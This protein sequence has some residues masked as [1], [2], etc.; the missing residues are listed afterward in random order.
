MFKLFRAKNDLDSIY[1]DQNLKDLYFL[2]RIIKD[3][4]GESIQELGNFLKLKINSI[5]TLLENKLECQKL[6]LYTGLSLKDCQDQIQLLQQYEELGIQESFYQWMEQCKIKLQQSTIGKNQDLRS[7]GELV[8][9]Q[10]TN[11]VNELVRTINKN[12]EPTSLIQLNQK[13]S[14]PLI[15]I[16]QQKTGDP[17]YK[18]YQQKMPNQKYKNIIF[19]GEKEVGKTTLIN[20][21]VNYYF[22]ITW[23]DNFRLIVADQES[24]QEIKD[25]YVEPHNQRDYGIHFIDTPGIYGQND[26][27]TIDQ[28]FKFIQVNIFQIDIIIV[29]FKEGIQKLTVE[30]KQMLESIVKVVG[31]SSAHKLIIARTFYQGGDQKDFDIFT[32]KNSPFYQI[33]QSLP[34][35]WYYRFNG[36]SMVK[37][38]DSASTY[39]S[40]SKYYQE[41]TVENFAN[42]ENN[43][44]SN[45]QYRTQKHENPIQQSNEYNLNDQKNDYH[46]QNSMGKIDNLKTE[47]LLQGLSNQPNN[48]T[49]KSQGQMIQSYSQQLNNNTNLTGKTNDNKTEIQFQN[50]STICFSSYDSFKQMFISCIQLYK[51][52]KENSSYFH[53]IQKQD[54]DQQ[55]FQINCSKHFISCFFGF[56]NKQEAQNFNSSFNNFQICGCPSN[57]LQINQKYY[58]YF[59]QYSIYNQN[60]NISHFK[61]QL[62]KTM[63]IIFQCLFNLHIKKQYHQNQKVTQEQ[64]LYQFIQDLKLENKFFELIKQELNSPK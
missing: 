2:I 59:E 40:A 62:K 38:Y 51:R 43:M 25:Y 45:N 52:N 57:T 28:I 5:Q 18:Y 23:E 27:Q 16:E 6:N 9:S 47:A 56:P 19:I 49:Q 63:Q 24:T 17:Q 4:S 35:E 15:K 31:S 50:F 39:Y 34:L 42:L 64:F 14:L 20:A 46:G 55:T 32:E 48:S 41:V 3:D 1:R 58:K 29:C 54:Q 53:F 22:G 26:Y 11:P 37:K 8:E 12:Q 60:V 7:Q 36:G 61:E 44:F 13:L 10:K 33:A 30:T 21:F